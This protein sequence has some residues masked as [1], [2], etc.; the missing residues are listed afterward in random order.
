MS[1]VGGGFLVYPKMKEYIVRQRH[2]NFQGNLLTFHHRLHTAY[3]YVYIYG[4]D[5]NTHIYTH[6]C[7]I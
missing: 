5:I 4:V 3:V 1:E 6:T 7:I 2:D